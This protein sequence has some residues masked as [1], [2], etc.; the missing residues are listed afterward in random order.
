MP[1]MLVSALTGYHHNTTGACGGTDAETEVAR[2]RSHG[3]DSENFAIF[4]HF[5]RIDD[6]DIDR[7]DLQH[8]DAFLFEEEAQRGDETSSS[9]SSSTGV[10]SNASDTANTAQASTG[11]AMQ[12]LRSNILSPKWRTLRVT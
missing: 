10:H 3:N 7:L 6:S 9:C 11:K 5:H 4:A 2:E 1:E 12:R 8:E